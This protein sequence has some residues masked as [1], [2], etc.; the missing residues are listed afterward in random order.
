MEEKD[1]LNNR[2]AAAEAPEPSDE[3]AE[4]R[5]EEEAIQSATDA[6]VDFEMEETTTT[7]Q[8][9]AEEGQRINDPE[10]KAEVEQ[11]VAGLNQEATEAEA[12]Y[13]ASVAD[14]PLADTEPEAVETPTKE[15]RDDGT[16][17]ETV[18]TEEN[19]ATEQEPEAEIRSCEAGL[20]P[21]DMT[22]L[23][24][25]NQVL[26]LGLVLEKLRAQGQEL[27]LP[28]GNAFIFEKQDGAM[29]FAYS[30]A[31]ACHSIRVSFAAA[32]EGGVNML[33]ETATIA[34][35][36]GEERDEEKIMQEMKRMLE[37]ETVDN[38]LREN[39]ALYAEAE[40]MKNDWATKSAEE[41]AA[42][43]AA[44]KAAF[45]SELGAAGSRRTK[46]DIVDS[47]SDQERLDLFKR[48]QEEFSEVLE[49]EKNVFELKDQRD[50]AKVNEFFQDYAAKLQD[51]AD[52]MKIDLIEMDDAGL[53]DQD[54]YIK[55]WLT[56]KEL[57]EAAAI[58]RKGVSG[59]EKMTEAD[60]EK[61]RGSSLWKYLL[62]LAAAAL[63]I[64]L[65]RLR[66]HTA[67]AVGKAMYATGHLALPVVSGHLLGGGAL[68]LLIALIPEEK[69]DK[70]MET[71]TGVKVHPRLRFKEK[72]K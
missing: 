56:I 39:D 37:D 28:P 31:G 62:P 24:G 70:F 67:G 57:E 7:N 49:R 59:P 13:H 65:D 60:V 32:A 12:A 34:D 20:S 19:A 25:E 6:K 68:A 18:V 64:I 45:S 40:R 5:M 33:I 26:A 63:I 16:K 29:L 15:S 22:V 72:T 50:A 27:P 11:E 10:K 58:F 35:T 2:P 52:L 54:T 47:E 3:Q 53:I 8:K 9:I 69:R 36:A 38:H 66:D 41:K 71:L 4:R 21:E 14:E 23:S 17:E 44:G 42:D 55:Q 30:V 48:H 51:Q 43:I 61:L 1:I 46:Q